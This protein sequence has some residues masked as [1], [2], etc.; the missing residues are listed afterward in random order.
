MR[1]IFKICFASCILCVLSFAYFLSSITFTILFF[2]NIFLFF[3]LFFPQI[4]I[5]GFLYFL[6]RRQISKGALPKK[7][8]MSKQP[9]LVIIK[10]VCLIFLSKFKSLLIY[11][12]PSVSLALKKAL[13]PLAIAPAEAQCFVFIFIFKSF[14]TILHNFLKLFPKVEF[15]WRLLLFVYRRLLLSPLYQAIYFLHRKQR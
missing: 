3:N 9:S 12:L 4:K 1:A 14:F 5:M 11:L 10:S 6:A 15:V 7:V 2:C 13:K 8:W